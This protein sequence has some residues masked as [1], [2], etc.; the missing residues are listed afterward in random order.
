MDPSIPMAWV[1]GPDKAPLKV[2]NRVEI[3][4]PI[5]HWSSADEEEGAI[6]RVM[7]RAGEATPLTVAGLEGLTRG[8]WTKLRFNHRAF[9]FHPSLLGQFHPPEGTV[10]VTSEVVP[11]N[12]ILCLGRAGEVGTVLA[13]RGRS[14]YALPIHRGVVAVR[15]QT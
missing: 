1:I 4:V 8:F 15:I 12:R 6:I 2:H 13:Q 11:S 10:V 9:V 7:G 5:H 14:G 3:E